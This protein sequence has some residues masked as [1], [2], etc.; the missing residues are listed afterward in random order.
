MSGGRIL[1]SLMNA[2]K[3]NKG[4]YGIATLCNGGGFL[5]ILIK[6]LFYF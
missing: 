3:S 5:L 4:K 1:I 6:Y 2:L